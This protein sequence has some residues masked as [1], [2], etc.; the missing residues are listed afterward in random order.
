MGVKIDVKDA[1]KGAIIELDND[2]FRVIDSSFMQCQQR[3]GN[4]TLRLKNLVT[5][6][7]LSK[8]FK[9]GTM[10]DKGEV[11]TKNAVFLY[12]AGDTYAF[13]ENDSGEIHDLDKESI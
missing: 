2:L 4:Y 8:P 11:I 10:L 5:G 13:M 7:V 12:S 1:K 3:Q 9:S 6:S